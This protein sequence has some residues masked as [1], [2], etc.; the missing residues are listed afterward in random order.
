MTNQ[1]L[2]ELSKRHSSTRLAQ[3][4]IKSKLLNYQQVDLFWSYNHAGYTECSDGIKLTWLNKIKWKSMSY[5]CKHG[6]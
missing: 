2:L 4:A 5:T 3:V 6:K 1:E